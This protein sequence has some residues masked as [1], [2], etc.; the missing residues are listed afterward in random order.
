MPGPDLPEPL[1]VDRIDLRTLAP[2]RRHS[3]T[4]RV[5]PL[6]DGSVLGVPVHVAMGAKPGKCLALVAGVHG[7]EA[8]GMAALV[9]LWRELDPAVL[10]GSMIL[11][12]VANP[13]AFGANQRRSPLDG[14]DLNRV[15]PGR[16]QGTPS[17]RLAHALFR[18]AADNAQFLWTLHS[19]YATGDA[20]PHVEVQSTPSPARAPSLAAALAAGFSYVKAADWHPGLFPRAIFDAGIPA[21]ESELGGTGIYTQAHLDAHRRH[22]AG[23]M[24]HLG[25]LPGDAIW[26]ADARVCDSV[27]VI[28]PRGGML[29]SAVRLGQSVTKGE[30]MATIADLHGTVRER[31]VA[32][33][34]GIVAAV[35]AFLSVSAGDLVFRILCRSRQPEIS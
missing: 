30:A 17:E 3:F 19:W 31:L 26:A 12:P 20:L 35:R 13:P 9:D 16:P 8:E 23:L 27:D 15:F 29:R 25:L 32:P 33:E 4:L 11:V 21:M 5:T 1:A 7:D 18:L 10:S 34:A 14:L 28:A 24:R 2:G 6:A 22:I